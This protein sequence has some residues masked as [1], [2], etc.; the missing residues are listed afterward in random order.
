MLNKIGSFIV[1]CLAVL[2]L[3]ALIPLAIIWFL[4][5][6]IYE[7]GCFIRNPDDHRYDYRGW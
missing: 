1:G 7:F 2:G 3:T 4:I 5:V 6:S